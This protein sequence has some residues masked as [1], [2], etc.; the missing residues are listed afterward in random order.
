MLIEFCKVFFVLAGV[1]V[2][3][4]VGCAFFDC[5]EWWG[6]VIGFVMLIAMVSALFV[7]L[8]NAAEPTPTPTVRYVAPDGTVLPSATGANRKIVV[9]GIAVLSVTALPTPTATPVK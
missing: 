1:G 7:G 9:R 8:S 5:D 4:V 2:Y 3:I 6:P